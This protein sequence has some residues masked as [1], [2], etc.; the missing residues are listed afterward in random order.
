MTASLPMT[1]KAHFH[2]S[3]LLNLYPFH[4]ERQK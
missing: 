3:K 1:K 2:K 4:N